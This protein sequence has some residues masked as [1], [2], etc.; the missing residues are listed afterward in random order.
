MIYQVGTLGG[1]INDPGFEKLSSFP[2]RADNFVSE[3]Q[4]YWDIPAQDKKLADATSE[5]LKIT[6]Q[7]GIT[8][9][10]VNYCS[11]EFSNWEN[12]YYGENYTRLQAIKCKYDP[13][14][15]IRHPQSIK[16]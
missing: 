11:L 13:D 5:I 16:V 10:Y 3:L 12:A 8:T 2:H 4:A 1:K 6:A 15:N 14:N 9:Q 7:N